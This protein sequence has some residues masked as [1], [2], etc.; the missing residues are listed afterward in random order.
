MERKLETVISS[1]CSNFPNET[2]R[3]MG[4]VRSAELNETKPSHVLK[5]LHQEVHRMSGAASCLGFREIAKGLSR[6]ESRMDDVLLFGR[7]DFATEL[8]KAARKIADFVASTPPPTPDDSRLIQ[9]GLLEPETLKAQTS[10][11]MAD[12]F[13][14]DRKLVVID[15][16]EHVRAIV[17]ETLQALGATEISSFASALDLLPALKTLS[18]DII[19]A[20]W[21]MPTLSGYDL[22]QLVRA[23][24]AGC[25]STTPFVFFTSYRDRFRRMQAVTNGADYLLTKPVSPGVLVRTLKS[26]T[27]GIETTKVSPAHH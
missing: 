4:L 11:E 14:R 12:D 13:L 16:D 21:E 27:Q 20:D 7:R 10:D 5:Q 15:D 17:S 1:Y 9:R 3:L 6:I 24:T 26:V 23:D 8:E 2:V 25:A 18:P 19:L 22:L